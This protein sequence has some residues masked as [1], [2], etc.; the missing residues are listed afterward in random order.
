MRLA[1]AI[2][3]V[4]MMEVAGSGITTAIRDCKECQSREPRVEF[5]DGYVVVTIYPIDD[6]NN[7][8]EATI[9]IPDSGHQ[10]ASLSHLLIGADRSAGG[11]QHFRLTFHR[12]LWVRV[13]Q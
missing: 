9:Q 4:G 13:V 1:H 11:R 12:S 3:S 5:K 7:E 8:L 2:S 10:G 6:W